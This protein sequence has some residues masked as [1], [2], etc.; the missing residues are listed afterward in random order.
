MKK[1][2]VKRKEKTIGGLMICDECG[3]PGFVPVQNFMGKGRF[4]PPLDGETNSA[5][6]MK[7][8]QSHPE[9]FGPGSSTVS[10]WFEW[11]KAQEAKARHDA[12]RKHIIV[13][14]S[15]EDD[16]FYERF[17]DDRCDLESRVARLESI[18]ILRQ[19]HR[20]LPESL[21]FVPEQ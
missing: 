16:A 10:T 8:R 6:Y 1:S 15:A 21:R 3:E 20:R 19:A 7:A 13:E 14:R 18:E 5:C 9:Q 11:A 2:L 4:C 17:D 12:R